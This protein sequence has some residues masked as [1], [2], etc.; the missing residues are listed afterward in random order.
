MKNK[1][2]LAVMIIAAMLSGCSKADTDNE[3]AVIN[4]TTLAAE[5][6]ETPVN[7]D[8]PADTTAEISTAP[9]VSEN[10]SFTV[11]FTPS[12]KYDTY[13]C[14]SGNYFYT[15]DSECP[16][17]QYSNPNYAEQQTKIN[18]YFI[19]IQNSNDGSKNASN[20][21]LIDRSTVENILNSDSMKNT[22]TT[23]TYEVVKTTDK[24]CSITISNYNY[25]GGAHGFGWT[26][27]YVIDLRSGNVLSMSDLF[28][29]VSDF[30]SYAGNYI[31]NEYY[32]Q[33]SQLLNWNTNDLTEAI[34][35]DSGANWYIKDNALFIEYSAYTLDCYAAGSQL[36]SIPL[37]V[38]SFYWSDLAKDL[39]SDITPK[40][41][42]EF[43]SP[44]ADNSSVAVTENN[45]NNTD[46]N[47]SYEE[48]YDN[49]EYP[50]FIG[51][52][53]TENDPLNVR[54]A[55]STSSSII[56]KI[57]KG[58]SVEI[59]SEADGWCEIRYNGQVGYV[60]K[61]YIRCETGGYAKPVIY[62]YPEKRTDVSVK[63]NFRNGGFTCTYPEYRSGWNVTA[64]PDGKI[65]NKADNDE[66]SYLYWEGEGSMDYDFSSGF[67]VKREDTAEFLKE[68][69]SY[70]GLTPKE[71]N[72]FIVYWLPI[73][74]KNEYNLISFQTD[75]Y[76]ESAK[77]EI[78]PEP[79]SVLRV[80]MAF[81]K[82]DCNSS[83]PQQKLNKF[84][85]KG[86][87]VIEWGGTEV[88]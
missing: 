58:S 29:P 34:V 13:S 40:G 27:G 9:P 33:Y 67:V 57:D 46:N 53:N 1:K 43:N 24:Y 39:F 22:F 62:L 7:T 32:S 83:V 17:I 20:Y 86:F 71:Y 38:C 73:M 76:D 88:K 61:E 64:Y 47:N 4:E 8:A 37:D 45:V 28:T 54:S 23:Q 75:N 15:F 14:D 6:T 41:K 35:P 60:S 10:D 78:S 11:S 84:E 19:D 63:V 18:N 31:Y 48:S 59:Y 65:I 87:S 49:E 81:R 42:L 50:M 56:G 12:K 77:L 70:M 25:G 26:S 72:E 5:T 51:I 80:F 85:R 44:P 79:D 3:T 30:R 55:P 2:I 36:V 82:A 69:L 16:Q 66:Y 52:V 74:Q 21:Q 68:K